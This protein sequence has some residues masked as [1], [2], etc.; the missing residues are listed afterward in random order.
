MPQ[1][2]ECIEYRAAS[3]KGAA[4]RKR[5]SLDARLIGVR[6]GAEIEVRGGD[7]RRPHRIPVSNLIALTIGGERHPIGAGVDDMAARAAEVRR[8]L[9]DSGPD[10]RMSAPISAPPIP[11]PAVSGAIHAAIDAHHTA[12][13]AQS[14][15]AAN[16]PFLARGGTTSAL[17]PERAYGCLLFGIAAI[18]MLEV[19]V[20]IAIKA[21]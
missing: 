7:S 12:P 11:R 9:G 8:L 18:C 15:S 6:E 4:R 5:G 19:L 21:S 10:A 13:F 1:S 2:L 14:R 17:V 20:L 3:A 16:Q